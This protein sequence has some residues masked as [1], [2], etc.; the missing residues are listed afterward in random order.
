M[1]KKIIHLL[2]NIH[3]EEWYHHYHRMTNINGTTNDNLISLGK[4]LLL[5]THFFK[6]QTGDTTSL[7]IKMVQLL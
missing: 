1:T 3:L 5:T 4:S 2:I 6:L 7:K